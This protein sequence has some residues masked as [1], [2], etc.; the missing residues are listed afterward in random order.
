MSN[1]TR[2]DE[3]RTE[4]RLS[5]PNAT[6]GNQVPPPSSSSFFERIT[7]LVMGQPV[8]KSN[9]TTTTGPGNSDPSSDKK[10][11]NNSTSIV[12]PQTL[13][14]RACKAPTSRKFA[15][16][17]SCSQSNNNH[18]SH[19]NF[20]SSS[21]MPPAAYNQLHLYDPARKKCLPTSRSRD[22]LL[23][24]C[25]SN[26]GAPYQVS[27]KLYHG[28]PC[29]YDDLVCDARR[30]RCVCKPTLHLYYEHSVNNTAFGCVPIVST[31]SQSGRASCKS[32]Y[33]YNVISTECQKIFD[34][35]ELPPN[36]TTGVSAT[37][38]SFVTIVLIWMLLFTLIATT[39]LRKCR[40]PN[41]HGN[42]PTT[43]RRMHRG[44][45]YRPQSQDGTYTWLYPFI[46]AANGRLDD[47]LNHNRT[48]LDRQ[49]QAVEDPGN[50]SDTDFFL[51]NGNRRLN[52]LFSDRAF[53]G[54]QQSLNNP[55]P[56]F[57][58][59]YP[60]CPEGHPINTQQPLPPPST[61]ELPTYDEAMKLQDT[62]PTGA[63][64]K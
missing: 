14:K 4:G 7:R 43:S 20:N 23:K 27:N 51:S 57:E 17:C 30:N 49:S 34:V 9:S 5:F 33:I 58:E 59:I 13:P 36:Q 6:S 32:G 54:S 15:H 50:F 1:H 26:M 31:I 10:S 28:A 61:E 42:S 35:N 64:Q 22:M 48:T 11:T 18:K 60:S 41:L 37:H 56:K 45:P 52:E 16:P 40:Y 25:R 24:E 8:S 19:S 44:G 63:N 47:Y 46:A 38:F 21:T 62:T 3:V 2:L 53:D 29:V 12:Q 39:K 55:P